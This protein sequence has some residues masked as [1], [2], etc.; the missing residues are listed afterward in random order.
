MAI[1][2]LLSQHPLGSW[3]S[4]KATVMRTHRSRPPPKQWQVKVDRNPSPKMKGSWWP[5]LLGGGTPQSILNM[6][7]QPSM[8]MSLSIPQCK[9]TNPEILQFNEGRQSASHQ[10]SEATRI[11]T[12]WQICFLFTGSQRW[13][14]FH[15]MKKWQQKLGLCTHLDACYVSPTFSRYYAANLRITFPKPV[16]GMVL[17]GAL[18]FLRTKCAPPISPGPY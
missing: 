12:K 18:H 17:P 4:K 5:L 10:A 3:I 13:R 16:A 2:D 1:C 15:L 8:A 11:V 9:G 14:D 7:L 6:A